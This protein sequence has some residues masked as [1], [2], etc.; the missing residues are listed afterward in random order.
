MKD[1]GVISRI[2]Q[3]IVRVIDRYYDRAILTCGVWQFLYIPQ[4]MSQFE[5]YFY[6]PYLR[7]KFER[8]RSRTRFKL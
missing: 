2:L 3:F 5:Q 6:L 4:L 8:I 1:S 7:V